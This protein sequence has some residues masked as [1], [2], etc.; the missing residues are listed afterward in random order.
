MNRLF[1][2][3]PAVTVP[4]GTLLHPV[5]GPRQLH[6]DGL[7]IVEELSVAVGVLPAGVRS[8]VHVHPIVHHLTWVL[9]GQLTV[10]MK[11]HQSDEPYQL[12]VPERTS[13]VTKPGTFFQL[14]NRSRSECQVLYIVG[15]AFVFELDEDNKV[16]YND[17]L[18]LEE[19]WED[20]AKK[21]WKVPAL[22]DLDA[23]RKERN[24]S[25]ERLSQ[26]GS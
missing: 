15:P 3:G 4:D 13:V 6:L 25:L 11:D 20:L 7:E 26:Q 10:Q 18:V 2:I 8:S 16:L 19:T 12:D 22:E 14:I 5:I 1:P 23:I 24:A 17:A 21:N 9:S